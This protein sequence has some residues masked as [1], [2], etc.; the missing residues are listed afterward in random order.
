M[1]LENLLETIRYNCKEIDI[2]VC[3]NNEFDEEC[4]LCRTFVDKDKKAKDEKKKTFSYYS[5]VTETLER[6]KDFKVDML[7]AKGADHF[8]VFACNFH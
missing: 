8:F 3:Y 2:K 5:E 4:T 7:L 1:T 6:Y